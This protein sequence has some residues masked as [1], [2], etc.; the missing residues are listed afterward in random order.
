LTGAGSRRRRLNRSELEGFGR[1]LRQTLA[2]R[3][4]EGRPESEAARLVDEGERLLAVPDL[5]GTWLFF[6]KADD[7]LRSTR[8]HVELT[9]RPRGLLD[10]VGKGP[11]GEPPSREEEALSNRMLLIH[12]LL[13]VRRASCVPVDDLLPR[14]EEAEA[15]YRSG[16]WKRARQLTD[17]VHA[18]LESRTSAAQR[19]S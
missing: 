14:L 6:A 2:D 10:Y 5:E 13:E 4:R 7:I 16:D 11:P 9:E 19:E 18:G 3:E 8:R 15:A 12:R 17:E 1:G